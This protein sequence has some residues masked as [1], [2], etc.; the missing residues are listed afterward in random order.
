MFFHNTPVMLQDDLASLIVE[1][2]GASVRN[3]WWKDPES[4][5]QI[6]R[7]FGELISLGHTEISEAWTAFHD[8]AMCDKPGLEDLPGEVEELAD[9]VIRVCDMSGGHGIPLLKAYGKKVAL[10]R[11]IEII[12]IIG[13]PHDDANF[14]YATLNSCLSRALEGWRVDAIDGDIECPVVAVALADAVLISMT[15][16][17]TLGFDLVE[18][19]Q[20]KRDYNDRRAD[21][22][23][24]ARRE[25]GGK[26]I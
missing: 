13:G 19:A 8:G 3:G 18:V 12:E 14:V 5:D 1:C 6:V 24:D 20:R 10:L 9:V 26:K 4:G 25:A 23:L 15:R 22:K 11:R 17:Q 7:N 2:H 16:A 21:H